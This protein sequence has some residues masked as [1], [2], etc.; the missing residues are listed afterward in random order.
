MAIG[1]GSRAGASYALTGRIS[2]D[3]AYNHLHVIS[4]PQVTLRN[5]ALA[6]SRIDYD[7]AVHIVSVGGSLSF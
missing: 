7:G 2:L 5:A 4:D 3:L 1:S 6:G